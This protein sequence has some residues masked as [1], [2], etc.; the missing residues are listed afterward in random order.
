[1]DN[2]PGFG[3]SYEEKSGNPALLWNKKQMTFLVHVE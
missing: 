2:L 1:M 3:I